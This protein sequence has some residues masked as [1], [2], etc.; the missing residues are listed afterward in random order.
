MATAA[1]TWISPLQ[2]QRPARI[3]LEPRDEGLGFRLEGFGVY[4]LGFRV[5]GLGF[6]ALGNLP[7]CRPRDSTTANVCACSKIPWNFNIL[8]LYG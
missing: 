8:G 1:P 6:E 4:S 5:W 3:C 2:C 7:G